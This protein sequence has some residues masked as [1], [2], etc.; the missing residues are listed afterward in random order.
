L[1]D[2]GGPFVNGSDT[3]GKPGEPPQDEDETVATN[4]KG[5]YK[6][7]NSS[8]D[9]DFASG[10]MSYYFGETSSIRNRLVQHNG[11]LIFRED[12]SQEKCGNL[13]HKRGCYVYSRYEYQAKCGNLAHNH[14]FC[15]LHKEN[16]DEVIAVLGNNAVIITPNKCSR[17]KKDSNKMGESARNLGMHDV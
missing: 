15:A 5:Y 3:P 14:G 7:D 2:N 6:F 9:E 10:L 8:I 16:I 11:P 4:E 17:S 12:S 13:S 1:P